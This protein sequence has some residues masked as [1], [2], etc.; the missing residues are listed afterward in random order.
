MNKALPRKRSPALAKSSWKINPIWFFL[1]L[2]AKPINSKISGAM[3][4]LS[5]VKVE[6]TSEGSVS[7]FIPKPS[8]S[9]AATMIR[10]IGSVA[11]LTNIFWMSDFRE[12]LAI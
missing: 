3:I 2:T 9:K 12:F 10:L 8:R 1:I 5:R 4:P 11:I 6:D 7:R